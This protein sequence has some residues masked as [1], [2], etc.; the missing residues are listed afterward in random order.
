M[1]KVTTVH[2]FALSPTHISPPFPI[3]PC[4]AAGAG[5]HSLDQRSETPD[6]IALVDTST[7]ADGFPLRP[8]S[9][10]IGRQGMHGE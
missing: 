4:M 8:P 3:L 9:I 6:I 7:D 1:G 5:S 10:F 2:R